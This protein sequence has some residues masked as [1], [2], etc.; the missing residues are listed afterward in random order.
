MPTS[1]NIVVLSAD[2]KMRIEMEAALESLSQYRAT[3]QFATDL[4]QAVETVRNRRPQLAIVEISPDLRALKV[5]ADELAAVSPETALAGAILPEIHA[6]EISESALL[7]G[8]VRAGVKD[9]LRR[10][11]SSTE[12][13]DLLGRALKARRRKDR[14]IAGKD[15]RHG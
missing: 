2:P 9:F 13:A 1:T 3:M 12:L 14:R 15:D 6:G 4:R 8:A 11:V 10:P 7:L 5:F